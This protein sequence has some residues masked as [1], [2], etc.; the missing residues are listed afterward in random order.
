MKIY[1]LKIIVLMNL[2]IIKQ[3]DCFN[4]LFGRDL[5]TVTGRNLA[6]VRE[7]SGENPWTPS[8]TAVREALREREQV[9]PADVDWRRCSYLVL[10]L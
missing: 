6:L 9:Q 7:E 2:L 1:I 10:L 5:R 3:V 4:I 8:T